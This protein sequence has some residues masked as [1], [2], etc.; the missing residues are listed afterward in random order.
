MKSDFGCH[1]LKAT[2]KMSI[3]TVLYCKMITSNSPNVATHCP[4]VVMELTE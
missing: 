4:C 1:W 3:F 2:C